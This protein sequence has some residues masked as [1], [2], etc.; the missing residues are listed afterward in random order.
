MK[1]CR[2]KNG[3]INIDGKTY[4]D[5]RLIDF[6][7]ETCRAQIEGEI[8]E[9][10]IYDKALNKICTAKEKRKKIVKIEQLHLFP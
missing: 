1:K 9:M 10:A 7:G 2:V 4:A 6:E 8:D 5:N 3:S